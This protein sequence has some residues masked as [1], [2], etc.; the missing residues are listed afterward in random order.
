MQSYDYS[1]KNQ[2]RKEARAVNRRKYLEGRINRKD[3]A[4]GGAFGQFTAK[5]YNLCVIG[6]SAPER[7]SKK[8]KQ[9]Y[10]TRADYDQ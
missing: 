6:T 3:L 7:N 1:I 8:S 4:H 10:E 5:L 2:R 9:D